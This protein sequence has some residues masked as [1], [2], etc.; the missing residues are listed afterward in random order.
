MLPPRAIAHERPWGRSRRPAD[1]GSTSFYAPAWRFPE[2][3]LAA[4]RGTADRPPP[5][6]G[7]HSASSQLRPTSSPPG[8]GRSPGSARRGLER[9][10]VQGRFLITPRS[11]HGVC[12][13]GSLCRARSLSIRPTIGL[14]DRVDPGGTMTVPLGPKRVR[15]A[16]GTRRR[17]SG[18]G[19]TS[20]QQPP[21]L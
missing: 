12:L 18:S 15:D 20:S 7:D 3:I 17:Q 11:G 9:T 21:R 5:S 16:T 13:C 19:Q 2:H 8:P 10:A 6:T 4:V 14:P 1:A